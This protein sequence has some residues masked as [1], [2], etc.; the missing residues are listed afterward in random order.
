MKI[1]AAFTFAAGLAKEPA[2]DDQH[3]ER[4]QNHDDGKARRMLV[5]VRPIVSGWDGRLHRQSAM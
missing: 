3:G 1:D 4:D 5:E 2:K